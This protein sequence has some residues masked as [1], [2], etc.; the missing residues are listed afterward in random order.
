MSNYI[1]EKNPIQN[2]FFILIWPYGNG[3]YRCLIS[4]TYLKCMRKLRA[5]KIQRKIFYYLICFSNKINPLK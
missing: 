1:L 5:L 2:K 4:V 3:Y